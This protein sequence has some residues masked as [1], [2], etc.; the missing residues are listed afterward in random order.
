MSQNL[1]IPNKD[2]K[3]VFVFGGID[4]AAATDIQ[5][6]FGAESYSLLLNPTVV[7]VD[8]ST[9]LSLDLSG[10]AEVGKIFA[11]V[12]FFDGSSVN[13]TDIT[14]RELG[15]SD[16]IVVAIGTQLIIEDGSVVANANSFV[17]DDEF[18]VY[19][20]LNN[21]DVP[22][23][24]PDREALLARAYDY[25][26]S[27][28]ESRIQ[29]YRVNPDVQTGIFPRI[30][31]YAY[32]Q[33]VSSDVVPNNAKTAQMLAALSIND[34]ADTNAYK[35]SADLASFNVQGVYSET[36]QSG[37]STPT[38]PEMPA[39]S[40]QLRPYTK[41]SSGGQLYRENMGFLY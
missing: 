17:T 15:N 30:G 9:E 16:K 12:T 33:S 26:N 19:A 18:K 2:N 38:I 3:V 41:A 5:V 40:R 34:G 28:Y 23:T 36:Y 39:V 14:S 7:S 10:T 22:A 13:G 25:N 37:S 29:G 35:D 21:Y 31:V 27:T 4:L 32:G 24:Q 6:Q 11:T 20:D 1:V 8:S